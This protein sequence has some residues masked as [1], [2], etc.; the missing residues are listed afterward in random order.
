MPNILVICDVFPPSFAPRMGYLVKYLEEFD[1]HAD[2]VTRSHDGDYSFGS[3]LGSQ[4]VM[5][6]ENISLPM[7]TITD[8]VF[9]LFRIKQNHIRNGNQISSFILKNLDPHKYDLILSSTAHRT[10]I[11]D[12]AYKVA[13]K[14]NKHLVVDIRDL[15]EQLPVVFNNNRG[16]KSLF[17]DFFEKSSHEFNIKRRNQCLK[18]AS[19]VTTV[20]PWHKSQIELINKNVLLIYN[21]YCPEQ[22][23]PRLN[24]KQKLFRI[25]YTGSVFSKEHQDPTFL[26]QATKKLIENK[27]IDKKYFRIQFYTPLNLRNNIKQNPAYDNIKDFV[28]FF[29][30]VDTS[31]VP[32]LL[33][34]SSIL[35]LLS[36]KLKQDG[37]K[38]LISTTK[39]FEYL[40]VERPILCVQSD[41]SLLEQS[42]RE[43]N[44]GLAARNV[45]D[46]YDF[47]LENWNE[48]NAKGFTTINVNKTYTQQFSRKLQAK[49][50]VDLFESIIGQSHS[51]IFAKS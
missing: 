15:Y 7:K 13:A 37:P 49:Q 46:T 24:K 44:A 21:G 27:N 34:N 38:G 4:K 29:D 3:L 6:V 18:Y 23:F 9:R 20:T 35:L 1:W 50:Y 17:I 26:F 22:F 41:E 16:I 12:A 32:E 48:W 14:W 39:Y 10:F 19:A 47:L 2:I 40:A 11:L 45:E 5:R 36:N 25:I 28:D 42:I 43:A 31:K 8:K 51:Q 33:N 30:Y